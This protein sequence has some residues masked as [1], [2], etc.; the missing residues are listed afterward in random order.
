MTKQELKD[1]I[2]T[3]AQRVLSDKLSKTDD[4]L[5]AT[6]E[7]REGEMIACS[8]AYV[9]KLKDAKAGGNAN[10]MLKQKNVSTLVQN[11][12]QSSDISSKINCLLFVNSVTAFGYKFC[13]ES[14][15]TLEA[16]NADDS[17]VM[18]VLLS[19]INL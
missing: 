1:K 8:L 14:E 17:F 13:A 19:V 5:L 7:D 2:T 4:V 3:I 16:M 12:I 15:T 6:D 10:I 11:C 18:N 9:L